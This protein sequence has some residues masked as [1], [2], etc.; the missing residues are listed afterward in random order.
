[1]VHRFII[2]VVLL[3][4]VAAEPG[5]GANGSAPARQRP[6]PQQG[7]QPPPVTIVSII[8]AQGEPGTIVTLYGSGFSDR[9]AAVLGSQ[10]LQTRVIG[11]KQLSFQL[12]QLPPGLYALFLKREDGVSSRT[13]SFTL[14]SQKPVITDL[15]PDTVQTCAAGREREVTIDGRNFQKGAQVLFDGAAIRSR[16][17][18][19]D[20]ITFNA[21]QVAGGQHQVQVRNPDDTSSGVVALFIDARPEIESVTQGEEYVNYYNLVIEGRN[22]QQG[23]AVVIMEERSL[24]QTTPQLAVEG[25]RLTSGTANP[26]D[27][28]RSVFINCNR[29]LYERH[30]YSTVPKNFK[31]QVINPNGEGSSVVSVN[32]P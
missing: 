30:P 13:Y 15:T 2:I 28:E 16:G 1:M 18:S 9:T 22:F 11:P 12:P 24:D 14:L 31:V 19:A 26:A 25:K 3:L 32:A 29:M 23:S 4:L 20:S 27:R 8:P 6:A 17:P 5:W 10:E 21:P 7:E